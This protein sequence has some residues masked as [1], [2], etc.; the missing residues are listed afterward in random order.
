MKYCL[1]ATQL[2]NKIKEQEIDKFDVDSFQE[3]HK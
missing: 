2:Q 1:E 3:N